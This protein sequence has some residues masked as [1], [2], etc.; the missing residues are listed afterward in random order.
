GRPGEGPG[1]LRGHGSSRARVHREVPFH[2]DARGA[3]RGS[4]AWSSPAMA[5][6][7]RGEPGVTI[8][9]RSGPR[10]AV[11]GAGMTG[12][13]T[14]LAGRVPTFEAADGPGGICASYYVRPGDGARQ[15]CTPGDG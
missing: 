12:L 11:L 4:A 1:S 5:G 10:L 3:D 2:G 15:P 13:A 8:G 14:G 7:A 6:P 9:R